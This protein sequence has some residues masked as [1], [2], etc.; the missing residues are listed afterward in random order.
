MFQVKAT[1]LEDCFLEHI[2]T[3]NNYVSS[4]CEI[5]PQNCLRWQ[6]YQTYLLLT[7]WIKCGLSTGVFCSKQNPALYFIVWVHPYTLGTAV[8]TAYRCTDSVQ[9]FWLGTPVLTGYTCTDW[10][11]L[12][13]LTDWVHLYSLL[14]FLDLSVLQIFLAGDGDRS[15]ATT[16]LQI[17]RLGNSEVWVISA[18]LVLS[19]WRGNWKQ[20]WWGWNK[21]V[22]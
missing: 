22:W 12:Y 11:H 13:W 17:R 7:I 19:C 10:V 8:L 16:C 1:F 15:T 3:N 18:L 20:G 6:R 4:V 5:R 14:Y 2:S 9:Q 21:S